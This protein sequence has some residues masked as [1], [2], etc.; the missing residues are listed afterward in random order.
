M[1]TGSIDE[2]RAL[3]DL[4]EARRALENIATN[5]NR[6]ANCLEASELR[7][8]RTEEVTMEDL[9]NMREAVGA[10]RRGFDDMEEQVKAAAEDD[11]DA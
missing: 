2:R 7:F 1:N 10:V 4:S 11:D 5:T 8:R 9:K 3:N 6:I